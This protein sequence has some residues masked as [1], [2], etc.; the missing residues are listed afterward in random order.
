[1]ELPSNKMGNLVDGNRL[2]EGDWEFG[3]I[4]LV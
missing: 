4:G 3:F 1:M 2:G